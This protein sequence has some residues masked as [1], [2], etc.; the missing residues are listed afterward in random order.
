ML[1]KKINNHNKKIYDSRWRNLIAVNFNLARLLELIADWELIIFHHLILSCGKQ[2]GRVAKRL[3]IASLLLFECRFLQVRVAHW[4]LI[5][6]RLS[7][8]STETLAIFYYVRCVCHGFLF[9]IRD[10][11]LVQ[12]PCKGPPK[13]YSRDRGNW[14][15]IRSRTCLVRARKNSS[16][17]RA[18]KT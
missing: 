10:A 15:W 3:P 4:R 7:R 18:N 13:E 1:C 17:R 14:S 6:D 12:D 9:H 8:Y 16:P 11:I 2:R 5:H